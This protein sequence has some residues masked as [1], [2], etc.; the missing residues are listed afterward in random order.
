M[1]GIQDFKNHSLERYTSYVVD[2]KTLYFPLAS[3]YKYLINFIY[4]YY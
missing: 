3:M 2:H 1:I 4:V